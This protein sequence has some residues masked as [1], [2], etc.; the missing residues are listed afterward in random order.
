LQRAI[1]VSSS[2]SVIP[3]FQVRQVKQLTPQGLH[4]VEQVVC[5]LYEAD[6]LGF[7]GSGISIRQPEDTPDDRVGA[8][9]ALGR[10]LG[11]SNLTPTERATVM[12]VLNE[13]IRGLSEPPP[14]VS[15]VLS[16]AEYDR[17]LKLARAA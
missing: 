14:P 5:F 11:D 10:A 2:R 17:R 1:R 9:R 15:N 12:G 6:G 4:D 8:R 3:V 16:W 7:V 13:F